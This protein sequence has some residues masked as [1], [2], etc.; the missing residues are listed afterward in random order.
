MKQI[1]L[2]LGSLHD[3]QVFKETYYMACL[4][5]KKKY[6]T[7]IGYLSRQAGAILLAQDNAL[8][9]VHMKKFIVYSI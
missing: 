2:L 7:V 6:C 3:W 4:G 5:K 9:P 8:C 1:F